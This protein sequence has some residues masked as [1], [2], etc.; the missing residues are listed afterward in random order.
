M[1][2]TLPDTRARYAFFRTF[3]TRWNDNDIYGHINNSVY[4]FYVDTVVNDWLIERGLLDIHGGSGGPIGLAVETGFHFFASLAYPQTITA[5]LRVGHLGNSSVRYEVGLFGEEDS[6][7]VRG[8]FTH[9]YVDEKTRRPVRISDTMR[10][11]LGELI[12]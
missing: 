3:E 6:T 9:V 7:A 11:T 10:K 8:R 4:G 1:S 12:K 2:R 5:G